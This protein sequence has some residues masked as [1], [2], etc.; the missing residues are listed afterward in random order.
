MWIYNRLF[1]PSV[2]D[3]PLECFQSLAIMKSTAKNILVQI[4][5]APMFTFLLYL[6]KGGIA[7]L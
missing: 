4:F 6:M 2:L 7:G 1:I 3:E 5:G